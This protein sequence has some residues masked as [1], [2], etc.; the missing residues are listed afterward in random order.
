M[1]IIPLN[2]TRDSLLVPDLV[3]DGCRGD[4]A[5]EVDPASANFG[6]MRARAQLATAV[7]IQWMTDKWVL[8][9]ELPSGEENRGWPGEVLGDLAEGSKFWLLRRRHL[10]DPELPIL[11]ENYGREALQ[12]LIDQKA[13]ARVA[14]TAKARPEQRRLDLQCT[15]YSPAGDDVFAG[16]FGILWE[17]MNGLD[18]PLTQ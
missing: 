13:V 5:V 1:R 18:Y 10:G 9:E 12:V 15:L 7:L 2:T 4:L 6:G 16:N 3:W 11:A 14:V 17:Q 8:P